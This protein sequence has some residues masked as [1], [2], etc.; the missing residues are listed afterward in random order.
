MSWGWN[1]GRINKLKNY[2]K[3]SGELVSSSNYDA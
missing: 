3:T 2:I 1:W